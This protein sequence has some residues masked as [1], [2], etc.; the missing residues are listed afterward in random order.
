MHI[1]AEIFQSIRLRYTTN[2]HPSTMSYSTISPAYTFYSSAPSGPNAFALF[3]A[4]QSPRDTYT[5]YEDASQALRP[6]NG[7]AAAQRKMV[8][9]GL[10]KLFGL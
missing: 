8:K 1:T 7:H 3:S 4:T 6:S 9:S 10:K 5:M 2:H